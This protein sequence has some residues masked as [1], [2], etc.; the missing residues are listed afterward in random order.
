MRT[1][2][3][4]IFEPL[5]L[6]SNV[7]FFH[8]WRYVFHGGAGWVTDAWEG[9]RLFTLDPVPAM[10]WGSND[11]PL[12]IRLRAMPA[13]VSERFLKPEAPWEGC[14]GAPTVIRENGRYRLWYEAV[15]PQAIAAGKAGDANFL[16][17]AESGDGMNWRRPNL[18]VTA[19]EAAAD[20]NIAY[21]GHLSPVWGYHGGSVF[22]DPS[23]PPTERYKAWHLAILPADVFEAYSARHPQDVDPADRRGRRAWAM[24]GAVSPDGFHWTSLPEPIVAQMSDTQNICYYDEFL[25][26]YVAYFRTWVM[27][28]RSIG[29]AESQDFRHFPLPETILWPDAGVGPADLWYSNGKTVYPGS[30]DYHL[31]FPK[32][33]NLVADRFHMHVMT[34]PDG[35]LWGFPPDSEVLSPGDYGAWNA[36]GVSIGCGMTELP[37]GRVGVPFVGYRI[38]H[39]YTRRPP[40]GEFAWAAW[41]KDRIVALEAPERGEFRTT[42]VLFHGDELRLNV[43]TH[44]AGHV[45]VEVVGAEGVAPGYGFDDCDPITG[46]FA[47]RLVTWKGKSKIPRRP[48]A[49]VAFRVRMYAAQLFSMRFA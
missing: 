36:G 34:S 43:R 19:Y 12:G 17:Y 42:K 46:D 29:R 44:H 8:D 13:Q 18:A 28:R 1:P 9:R 14:I 32:R 10:T 5:E 35:I 7:I 16:C 24:C 38:P 40:L 41:P 3:H 26:K 30:P 48:D 47:D 27:G 25:K 31:L 2:Y 21:G 33:W 20:T 15:S 4:G 45:C 23:A 6:R 37:G 39:K 49:P 11:T 22:V